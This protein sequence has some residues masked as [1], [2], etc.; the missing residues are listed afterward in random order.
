MKF[1]G[2][3]VIHSQFQSVTIPRSARNRPSMLQVHVRGLRDFSPEKRV[4]LKNHLNAECTFKRS[5]FL[6]DLPFMG[7]GHP[8]SEGSFELWTT[9]DRKREE[10]QEKRIPVH[11]SFEL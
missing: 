6:S 4:L 8:K 9:E 3:E 7:V 5:L 11:I 2:V 10:K 1:S